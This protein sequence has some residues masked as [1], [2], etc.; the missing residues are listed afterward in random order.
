MRGRVGFW[1][2]V[3][4]SLLWFVMAAGW[5]RGVGRVPV[6]ADLRNSGTGLDHY[7]SV[8]VVVAARDEAETLGA[9]LR[10]I[11]DQKYPGR[12]EI[13][14]VDDRSADGTG[15]VLESLASEMPE[16]LRHL[17]VDGLP[18]GW[19]GK[20]HALWVGAGK[21]SGDWLL[22]TD[23][24]VNFAPDCLELAVRHATNEGY[25]HLTLAPE[26]V[27]HRTTLKS[28]ISAFVINRILKW[29]EVKV[30]VP[31]MIGGK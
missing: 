30:R 11:M 8:S 25:D 15:E 28:F 7:T 27:A 14:A 23:A 26:L 3:L 29:V 18:E 13:V 31:G 22:F 5:F 2:S 10:S 17:R 4:C 1:I 21:A 24:D 6:L 12:L 9:A 19:L 20:N 16:T